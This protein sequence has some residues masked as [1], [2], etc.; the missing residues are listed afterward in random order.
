MGFD[1]NV[2]VGVS[3][4]RI[5]LAVKHRKHDSTYVAGIECDGAAYHSSRSARDRDRLREDVLTG[6]GWKIIRVWSTDWFADPNAETLRLIGEIE[7]LEAQP[8]RSVD[9]FFFGRG[10]TVV[11]EPPESDLPVTSIEEPAPAPD[12]VVAA[13]EPTVVPPPT[14]RASGQ[15]PLP[16]LADTGPLSKDETRLALEAFRKTVIEVELPDA[17]SQRCILRKSMI[18]CF[19]S[20]RFDHPDDWLSRIPMYLRQGTDSSQRK[21]LGQICDIVARMRK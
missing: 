4:F 15:L 13:P 8:I 11:E 2:Q 20:A 7:K 10:A 6:L 12:T 9:D 14:P 16:L 1:V 3:Q 5:D 19:L 17:P 21:Y 18:E